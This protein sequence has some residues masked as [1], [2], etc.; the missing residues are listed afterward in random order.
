[1]Y[2]VDDKATSETLGYFYMDLH[3][4]EGKFGHAAMWDM[5]LGTKDT[6]SCFNNYI[7]SFN[8]GSLDSLGRRQKAIAV[9]VC[10]FPKASLDRPALMEHGQVQKYFHEFGHIM[11]GICSR[12]GRNNILSQ[13]FDHFCYRPTYLHSMGQMQNETLWKHQ[14]KC[15]QTG[16]GKRNL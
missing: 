5:Q 10:N 12:V 8:Q 6:K 7:F 9:I 1:M 2:Q 13:N 14:V 16:L 4:R 15:F 3:P 11:H